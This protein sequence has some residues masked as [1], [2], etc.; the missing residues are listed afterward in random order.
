MEESKSSGETHEFAYSH[1]FPSNHI[2]ETEI[3]K[4][5]VNEVNEATNGKVEITTYP[6]NQLAEAD[7]HFEVAATGVADIGVS[8]HRVTQL[9]SFPSLTSV[10]E[11]PFISETG[12]E[13][14]NILWDLY[15][16]FPELQDEYEDVEPL[17]FS[18]LRWSDFHSSRTGKS[19][20]D[21]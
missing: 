1:V 18:T 7:G 20:E 10:I 21:L 5:F 8:V 3:A 14:S 2:M 17:R 13:G 19:V 11:L 9:I 12:I 15:E 16:E 4:T 6:G